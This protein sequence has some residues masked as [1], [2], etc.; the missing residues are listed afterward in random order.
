MRSLCRRSSDLSHA[1]YSGSSH[2]SGS[3]HLRG[4][5]AGADDLERERDLDEYGDLDRERER[6][7][8][9]ECKWELDDEADTEGDRRRILEAGDGDRPLSGIS[10]YCHQLRPCTLKHPTHLSDLIVPP[11]ILVR[12]PQP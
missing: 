6:D 3:F 8:E 7:R 5:S 10:S 11:Q 12:T 9:R 1:S 4:G 2:V